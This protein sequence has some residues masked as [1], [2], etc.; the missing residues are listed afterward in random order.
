[1]TEEPHRKYDNTTIAALMTLA[2]GGCYAPRCGAPTVR[3]IDG[4][5]VLNLD[6]AHIR[7][8]KAGGKRYDPSWSVE[9]RNSFANLLLL[10]NVHH[11]RVDGT[12]GEEYTVDILEGWKRVREAEGQDALAGLSGLTETRLV[13]MIQE[14]QAQYVDRLA[15]VLGTLADRV[16][17]LSSLLKVLKSDLERM[18]GRSPG[19]SEDTAWMVYE[20]SRNL[21]HLQDN[22]PLLMDAGDDLAHLQDNIQ[23]LVSAAQTLARV[24]DLPTALNNAADNIQSA[25]ASLSD[26]RRY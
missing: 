19:I 17:E 10:C 15:P 5:P 18:Q 3:I 7:A 14:A 11:K 25:A 13:T 1:M 24:V 4:K 16:P 6:I 2:R 21:A 26:A 12:D 23:L 9:E 20:A 22:A 8:L